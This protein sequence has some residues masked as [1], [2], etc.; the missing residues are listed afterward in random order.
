MLPFYPINQLITA[1]H[2]NSNKVK[3]DNTAFFD[4]TKSIQNYAQPSKQRQ[5]AVV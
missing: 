3:F 2:I 5:Q 1:I 4:I